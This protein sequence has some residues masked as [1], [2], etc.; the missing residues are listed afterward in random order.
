MR[1]LR[2][3]LLVITLLAVLL[4]SVVPLLVLGWFGLQSYENR[5]EAMIDRTSTLLDDM[6]LRN[7]EFRASDTAYRIGNFLQQRENELREVAVLPRDAQ[8]YLDFMESRRG[9]IWL[10]DFNQEVTLELPYY[11]EIAFM[12]VYGQEMVKVENVCFVYPLD[13]VPEV[14]ITLRDASNPAN[15]TYQSEDYFVRAQTLQDGEVFVSRPTGFYVLPEAAYRG[16]QNPNGQRFEGVI[17]FVTPVFEN[18]QRI[19]YVMLALDH[20]HLLE[21][22]THNDPTADRPVLDVEPTL[23]NLTYLIGSDGA[24][25]GHIVHSNIAGVDERGKPVP[26]FTENKPAGPGNFYRMGFLSPVFPQVMNLGRQRSQGTIERFEIN[27]LPRSMAYAVIPYYG[28]DLYDGDLGFGMVIVSVD[29]NAMHIGTDVFTTQISNDLNDLVGQLGGLITLTVLLVGVF[30]TFM[31][32]RVVNPVRNITQYVHQMESN[33]LSDK[34]IARLKATWGESEVAQ[35]ARTF[36]SMAE[37]IQARE[38][39]IAELL[40]RTDEALGDRV[41]EL[42]ALE[43]VGQELTASL[44]LNSVIDLTIR[45]LL[46]N[47]SAERVEVMV[48][49]AGESDPEKIVRYAGAEIIPGTST[50]LVIALELRDVE[51]GRFT[52]Y[53]N[54][55]EFEQSEEAFARQLGAWVSV[56][57]NN[58]RLFT[59]VQSQQTLLEAANL[60]LRETSRAKSEF[61]ANMSHELRTPLNAIIGYTDLL[62]SGIYGTYNDK[63]EDRLRRVMTNGQHLLSLIN[64]VLDLSKVEAGRMELSLETVKMEGVIDSVISTAR[65]LMENHQNTF[66]IDIPAAELGTTMHLDATRLRQMLLNLL[67]NAAKFTENGTVT[68]RL[69]SE[70]VA[71]TPWLVFQVEDTGIGMSPEETA[72]I[73]DAFTQADSS[74]TRRYGGT[75]LGLTITRHFTEMMGG[76]IRVDSTPGVGST[77]TLRVPR[78]VGVPVP[79]NIPVAAE[80]PVIAAGATVLVI[81]D[82]PAVREIIVSYLQGEGFHVATATSGEEGLQLAHDLKPAVITLDVMMPMMDGWEVLAQLKSAPDLSHIPVIMLSFMD[83]RTMG[84]ALGATDYMLK[85][86]SREALID[87]M[88]R[89]ASTAPTFRVLVVDDEPD[90]RTVIRDMLE[91]AG[92]EVVEAE[93]GRVALDKVN[94]GIGLILLDLMMPEVDGFEVIAALQE[95][96][97]HIP[98]IVVTARNLSAAERQQLTG[99]VSHILQKGAY[100]R[101]D[102]LREIRDLVRGSLRQPVQSGD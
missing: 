12:D 62:I 61:L 59:R 47:T 10:N 25:M 51:I 66:L 26:F 90:A 14:A 82:D 46:H 86:V 50:S 98:I 28:G 43:K 41:K 19:G 75:G 78:Y 2:S 24:T 29:Y 16:A 81:D 68:F 79:E 72:R 64:D 48:A 27:G 91:Q 34:A 38:R 42:S 60:Q 8:A 69:R 95:R 37:T 100:E 77:F 20:T 67:S 55:G 17:R 73:F 13:C 88:K 70:T 53:K 97:L 58:A 54:K 52:L 30:A 83:S 99:Q 6:A 96:Q 57:V 23:D 80:P 9:A 93:N 5:S 89:Y 11:R 49:P 102:L 35:L 74:T 101:S 33:T 87:V 32:V 44:D 85:P 21:F 1:W 3:Q 63:Q 65:P 18:E 92:W 4:T 71:E 7:L 36:G 45:Y 39:Q 31:A 56:A 15:T 76:Q 94:A 84:F 40:S 22:T